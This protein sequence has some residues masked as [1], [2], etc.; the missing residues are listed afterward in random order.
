[1]TA[2]KSGRDRY[3]TALADLSHCRAKRV[4]YLSIRGD[5][6]AHVDGLA[7]VG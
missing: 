4:A 3:D 5:G 7:R 6:H 2:T 1:M